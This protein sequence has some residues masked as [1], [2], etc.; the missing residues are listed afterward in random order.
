MERKESRPAMN[1]K[2]GEIFRNSTDEVDFIVK[3]VVRD[4]VV[5]ESDDGERQFYKINN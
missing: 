4:M 5:L 3:K 2:P 1:I